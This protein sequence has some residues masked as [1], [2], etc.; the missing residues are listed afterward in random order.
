MILKN[1]SINT[2]FISVRFTPILNT[3]TQCTVLPGGGVGAGVGG[4]RVVVVGTE[5]NINCVNLYEYF[6]DKSCSQ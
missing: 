2:W 1:P 6:I 3:E 5:N 4:T